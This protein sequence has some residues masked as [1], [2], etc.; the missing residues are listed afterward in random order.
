M[1][2]RIPRATRSPVFGF[3]RRKHLS[4]ELSSHVEALWKVLVPSSS[5]GDCRLHTYSLRRLRIICLPCFLCHGAQRG[6]S[7]RLHFSRHITL[8]HPCHMP[9]DC[10]RCFERGSQRRNGKRFQSIFDGRG[11]WTI[12]GCLQGVQ[13]VALFLFK[14]C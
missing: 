13:R 4:V 5:G 3:V 7:L 1:A 8:H 11:S 10:P 2:R 14:F 6:T 12:S 9:D